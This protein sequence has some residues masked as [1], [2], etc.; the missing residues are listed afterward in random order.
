M[1]HPNASSELEAKE[2]AKYPTMNRTT[3]FLN[4]IKKNLA[5]NINNANAEKPWLGVGWGAKQKQMQSMLYN[6]YR[7]N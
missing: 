3:R 7:S 5:Q 6:F 4:N 2:A 1:D